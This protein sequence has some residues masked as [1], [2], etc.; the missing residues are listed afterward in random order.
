MDPDL[1]DTRVLSKI[2]IENHSKIMSEQI[3]QEKQYRENLI[4]QQI[5]ETQQHFDVKKMTQDFNNQL[6]Q[7]V[8][9]SQ[10]SEKVQIKIVFQHNFPESNPQIFATK[11]MSHK[12]IDPDTWQIK[13]EQQNANEKKSLFQILNDIGSQFLI[14]APEEDLIMMEFSKQPDD[15]FQKHLKAI[16]SV[17][18]RE[19]FENCYPNQYLQNLQQDLSQFIMNLEDYQQ[20]SN[21][22][23]DRAQNNESLGVQIKQIRNENQSLKK[24]IEKQLIHLSKLQSSGF[25][26]NGFCV[27]LHKKF[28]DKELARVLDKKIQNLEQYRE[29]KYENKNNEENEK[30]FE[31]DVKEYLEKRK[32][33]QISIQ[34]KQYCV[35]AFQNK[36]QK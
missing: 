4:A 25:N 9:T 18:L 12:L 33:Y 27:S 26:L 34:K 35:R 11:Q 10:L 31:K 17:E 8:Y 28:S 16:K 7:D 15:Q 20:L 2:L 6:N 1:Q 13:V 29:E 19:L 3:N 21:L 22:I 32:E 5:K 36:Y 14:E 23:R 30:Q 24:E